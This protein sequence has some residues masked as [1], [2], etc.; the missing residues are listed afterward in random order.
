MGGVRRELKKH[1]RGMKDRERPCGQIN[2]NSN[3]HS[4]DFD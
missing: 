1:G 4:G 2:G 3:T